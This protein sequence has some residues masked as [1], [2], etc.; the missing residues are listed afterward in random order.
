MDCNNLG[1]ALCETSERVSDQVPCAE[2]VTRQR[3][4]HES[5]GVRP[6]TLCHRWAL[7]SSL[8][9]LKT[10]KFNKFKNLSR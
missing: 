9:S 2:G 5:E 7:P 8:T 10:F 3:V 1:S 4:S 6:S